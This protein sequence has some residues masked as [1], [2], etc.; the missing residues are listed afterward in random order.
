M[1]MPPDQIKEIH[2][3]AEK[4]SGSKKMGQESFFLHLKK[5]KVAKDNRFIYGNFGIEN[6]DDEEL[7]IS[8]KEKGIIK[9]LALS[10]DYVLLSGHRVSDP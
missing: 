10:S 8:I 7:T 2:N 4:S 9:P 5:I 6:G 3:P 1:R